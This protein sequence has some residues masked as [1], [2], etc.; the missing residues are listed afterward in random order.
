MQLRLS[1]R[2][3]IGQLPSGSTLVVY[4]LYD[5][6]R[7]YRVSE[8]PHFDPNTPIKE[9]FLRT[10]KNSNSQGQASIVTGHYTNITQPGDHYVWLRDPLDRDISH[11]NYDYKFGNHLDN[12]F[13]THLSLMSG[14]FM[15]LWLYGRYCGLHDSVTMEQRYNHVRK[16]LQEKFKK[17]YDTKNFEES[18]TEIANLL[19]IEVEPRLNSNRVDRDY[20]KIISRPALTE[21]FKKWH[22][23]YN[24]FDYL[25]HAEFCKPL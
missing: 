20:K 3:S 2:E 7:F 18:W 13:G 23:D 19:K 9:A 22:R 8:D 1:H 14:N 25:L 24:N 17:V 10:Y 4:P 21:E 6:T 5:E 15:V 12:D 11:F 16:I